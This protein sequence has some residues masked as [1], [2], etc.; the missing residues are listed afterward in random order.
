MG[1]L[2]LC[3]PVMTSLSVLVVP[4]SEHHDFESRSR[5]SVGSECTQC[6]VFIL[7]LDSSLSRPQ[8]D[9]VPERVCRVHR[10][11]LTDGAVLKPYSR[12]QDCVHGIGQTESR[13][14]R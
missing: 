1:G 8:I 13:M 10:R 3:W 6:R 2:G 11:G 7:G 5:V 12:T 4:R 9:P 14:G